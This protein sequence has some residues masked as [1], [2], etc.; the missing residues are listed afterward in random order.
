MIGYDGHFEF[1]NIGESYIDNNVPYIG[2][3][4]L[5]AILGSM[6][7]PVMYAIM[8]ESG[9]PRLVGLLSASLV[10]FGEF[11]S[12]SCQERAGQMRLNR[13]WFELSLQIMRI[14][15]KLD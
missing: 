14:L 6:V 13:S 2:L 8:R 12:L 15:L 7:P 9:Y 1:E 4:T 5:P 11:A 3:R 10:L